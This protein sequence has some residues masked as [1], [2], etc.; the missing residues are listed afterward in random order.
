MWDAE[1]ITRVRDRKLNEIMIFG[2]MAKIDSANVDMYIDIIVSLGDDVDACD[3]LLDTEGNAEIELDA[4]SYPAYIQRLSDSEKA[5]E[6]SFNAMKKEPSEEVPEE[7]LEDY[8][9]NLIEGAVQSLKT[10]ESSDALDALKDELK[11]CRSRVEQ[12]S[13]DLDYSKGNEMS[14]QEEIDSLKEQLEMLSSK[15]DD[16]RSSN[17]SLKTDLMLAEQ[18]LSVLEP[19][20]AE[21]SAAKHDEGS[22]EETVPSPEQNDIKSEVVSDDETSEASVSESVDPSQELDGELAGKQYGGYISKDNAETLRK[23][24]AMKDSKIDMLIDASIS[25][26][27]SVSVCDDI[28]DFLKIDVRI[29]DAILSIDFNNRSSVIEGFTKIMDIVKDSDEPK[30]QDDYVKLLTPEESLLEFSYSQVLNSL[31]GMIMYMKDELPSEA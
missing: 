2:S 14:L 23:V 31:Q 18:K 8:V 13:K 12:L 11:I 22:V 27:M 24:R 26:K 21:I 16:L 4:I 30:H 29:C 3:T 28:I 15:N 19:A 25:G 7:S 17:A 20:Y 10:P 1:L 5:D 6:D 9:R